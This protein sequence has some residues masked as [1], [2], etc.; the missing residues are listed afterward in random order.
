LGHSID[1]HTREACAALS[2]FKTQGNDGQVFVGYERAEDNES[3]N[4]AVYLLQDNA[5]VNCGLEVN[6][7]RYGTG[8]T[9]SGSE[10]TCVGQLIDAVLRVIGMQILPESGEYTVVYN[11]YNDGTHTD[12]LA[13][14]V[15]H[16]ALLSAAGRN[17]LFHAGCRRA[18]SAAQV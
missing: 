8:I 12:V 3:L 17:P 9:V 2:Q 7:M 11:C 15:P 16:D 13:E 4:P 18:D 1:R 5:I 6:G 14:N 10:D